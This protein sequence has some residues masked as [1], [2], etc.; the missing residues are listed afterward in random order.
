MYFDEEYLL[1][2]VSLVG[3]S[4]SIVVIQDFLGVQVS[5]CFYL[6]GFILL[7]SLLLLYVSWMQF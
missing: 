7:F 3:V 6:K 2:K 5:V 4:E 1:M